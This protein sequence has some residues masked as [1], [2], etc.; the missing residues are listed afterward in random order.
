MFKVARSDDS[1]AHFFLLD[2]FKSMAQWLRPVADSSRILKVSAAPWPKY[3][4]LH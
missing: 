3:F 4:V 2:Q 1:Y